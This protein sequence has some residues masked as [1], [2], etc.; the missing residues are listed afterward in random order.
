VISR[1]DFLEATRRFKQTKT[2]PRERTRYHALLLVYKGYTYRHIAEVLFIDEESVSRW[3]AL[4]DE[5][6]LDGLKNN[7][8][9]GGEHGQRWLSDTEL[10][11][12]HYGRR[13]IDN[14]RKRI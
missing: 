1:A 8:L 13:A 10:A 3:I 7:P 9:W 6:G 2:H 5:K 14:A 4:Y 12:R 11:R